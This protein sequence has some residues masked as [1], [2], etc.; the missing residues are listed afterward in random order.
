MLRKTETARFAALLN[1]PLLQIYLETDRSRL[2]GNYF[3][4]GLRVPRPQSTIL[5]LSARSGLEIVYLLTT[6]ATAK[7]VV[8]EPNRNLKRELDE[9][10]ENVPGLGWRDRVVFHTS[11]AE[12]AATNLKRF[13]LVRVDAAS[14]DWTAIKALLDD[15]EI[16]HICG[17]F[18]PVDAD[19]LRVY[20]YCRGRVSSFYW[21]VH[22]LSNPLSGTGDAPAFEVSVVVPAY[23][24]LPW[25]DRCLQTLVDQTLESLEIIAVDDGS[26]DATGERLDEWADKHPG[27]VKVVH[28]PNGGCA[29]ARNAGA[30]VAQGEYVAFV[31]GDDW[32][33]THMFEEL[34]RSAVLNAADVA[35]C[36]YL[37][38]FEDSGRVEPYSTAWGGSSASETYG[39]VKDPRSYLTVKPTIWRRIYRR[40]F[41]RG[42]AIEFPEH[43]PRFDDLP[44]QFEALARVKRMSV[45]PECY[46]Y[47]RQEREGQDIAV[48]DERLFV[49]F[50]I[51]EWLH[52]KVGAWADAGIESYL[53]KC[54]INTHL[55]ALSRIEKGLVAR[56]LALAIKDIWSHGVHFKSAGLVRFAKSFV[57]ASM[58]SMLRPLAGG[59][60]Q[61]T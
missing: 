27:R 37:E 26:P 53:L 50:P 33:D 60:G 51:F 17:S 14:F 47:Y 29:S 30:R 39:L 42:N 5:L 10:L 12:L 59:Q 28:K 43:I 24:V 7:V 57:V 18:G 38:A 36:G 15:F 1:G 4:L 21:N 11:A 3:G 40:E 31:D 16:E 58:R 44:F 6:S 2:E 25:I 54:K 61:R 22:G 8:V 55:W 34:Y 52:G 20:R 56:Y 13:A 35:Q 45:I 41:L 32:V 19:P 48:R 46:Y 23:K 9:C 49:H